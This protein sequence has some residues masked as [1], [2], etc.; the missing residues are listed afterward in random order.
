MQEFSFTSIEKKQWWLQN[1]CMALLPATNV[2]SR[3]KS[4]GPTRMS[5]QHLTCLSCLQTHHSYMIL[6][7]MLLCCT[8]QAFITT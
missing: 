5:C 1:A 4:G 7:C 8:T 3:N 6:C 2:K